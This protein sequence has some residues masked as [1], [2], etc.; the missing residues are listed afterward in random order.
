MTAVGSTIEHN[1]ERV[2]QWFDHA[3]AGELDKAM[4]LHHDHCRFFVSG[5]MPYGGWMDKAA[6]MNQTGVLQLAGPITMRFGDITAEGDRVWLEA[7][8]EATLANGNA[9]QNHYV[10]LFRFDGGKIIELKEFVDTL[11]VYRV[12]DSEAVRGQP[13]PRDPFVT[14]PSKTLTSHWAQKGS[15]D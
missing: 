11:H 9:Y 5:D 8:S 10:F 7:D 14:R 15:A 13:R 3:L 4:A 6:Y 2:W 1:K 12:I